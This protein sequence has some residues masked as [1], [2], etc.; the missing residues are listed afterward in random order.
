MCFGFGLR[1]YSM[2]IGRASRRPKSAIGVVNSSGGILYYNDI[3]LDKEKEE[4]GDALPVINSLLGL[5]T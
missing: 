1:R 5:K 2:M 4:N 3:E